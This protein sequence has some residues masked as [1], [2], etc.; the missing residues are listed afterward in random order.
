[1]TGKVAFTA[2]VEVNSSLLSKCRLRS[3]CKKCAAPSLTLS[4]TSRGFYLSAVPVL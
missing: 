2:L 1:M 4:Q 3:G